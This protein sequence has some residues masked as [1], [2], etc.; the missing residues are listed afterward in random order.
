MAT[1]ETL[2]LKFLLRLLGVEGYRSKISGIT[3]NKATKA[4]ERDQTCEALGAKGLV[5]YESEIAKFAITPPGTTLLKLD[6]TSLPVTPD[7]L[8]ILKDCK[9]TMTP[10]KVSRKISASDRQRLL[11]NLAERGLIKVSKNMIKDVWVSAQGKQFLLN[12]YEPQGNSLLATATM[13]GHYVQFMRDNLGP[14]RTSS[15]PTHQPQPQRPLSQPGSLL[16]SSTNSAM[17]VGSQTKPDKPAVL[18]QIQQLDQQIG[19]EN[20]LPI[21]HLRAAL[22]PP[23]TR[24]ELDSILYALQRDGK[25]DLDSLHDQGKYTPEQ[26]AAGILQDNGGYLFFIALS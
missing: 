17:P 9:G 1:N 10:S 25:I 23:L 21:Y 6:T 12:E 20:Y 15:L 18:S 16:G 22:Q 5:E 26:V 24:S 14:A 4:A 8:Q 3:L 13:L 2:E 11:S 19:N 7:E